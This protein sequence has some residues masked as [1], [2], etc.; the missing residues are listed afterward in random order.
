MD[1][2][3]CQIS[4]KPRFGV[5]FRFVI[6]GFQSCSQGINIPT[7]EFS[8]IPEWS[9]DYI[10]K[11]Q[12]EVATEISR[13]FG[14]PIQVDQQGSRTIVRVLNKGGQDIR[15]YKFYRGF[16]LPWIH[17]KVTTTFTPYFKN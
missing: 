13:L 12:K 14:N 4:P 10:Q 3:A 9:Y 11:N 7:L 6:L 17:N 5:H 2:D 15:N 16:G 8:E 1:S